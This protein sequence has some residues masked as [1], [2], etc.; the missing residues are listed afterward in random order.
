M[1]MRLWYV[2]LALFARTGNFISTPHKRWQR[3]KSLTV[4]ASGSVDET[5]QSARATPSTVAAAHRNSTMPNQSIKLL[6]SDVTRTD[7]ANEQ[8]EEQA[9][10]LSKSNLPQILLFILFGEQDRGL[11]PHSISH[12]HGHLGVPLSHIII[13]LQGTKMETF[14]QDELLLEDAGVRI[15]NIARWYSN[16]TSDTKRN[17]LI[18]LMDKILQQSGWQAPDLWLGLWDAD[19]F[20]VMRLPFQKHK[21]VSSIQQ[22]LYEHANADYNVL[23]GVLVDRV[24]DG[25]ALQ[26]ITTGPNSVDIFAQ[27]P[28]EC[29]LSS[30]WG[31]ASKVVAFRRSL[32]NTYKHFD[33]GG[34][35]MPYMNPSMSAMC[36]S[37][38]QLVEVSHFK[39]TTNLKHKLENIYYNEGVYHDIGKY[40]AGNGQ[41]VNVAADCGSEHPIKLQERDQVFCWEP[42]GF[43]RATKLLHFVVK[44]QTETVINFLILVPLVFLKYPIQCLLAVVFVGLVLFTTA[45]LIKGR[46]IRRKREK[47]DKSERRKHPPQAP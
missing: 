31:F 40:L 18:P 22:K 5:S 15:E 26:D 8:T 44:F 1:D 19:E 27:F 14:M 10:V 7:Y 17:F 30:K 9:R 28:N 16:Y 39:W 23:G 42:N 4:D 37:A 6:E 41:K 2:L 11:L 3:Q 38:G 13:V 34:H 35:H 43:V 12:I 32:W 25:G 20:P 45:S 33:K 29:G 47:K 46:F 24:A 21:P 36:Q